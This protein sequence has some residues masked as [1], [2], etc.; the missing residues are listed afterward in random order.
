[1]SYNKKEIE[2][3][4]M[5]AT[6]F[7]KFL[8]TGKTA[9]IDYLFNPTRLNELIKLASQNKTPLE[10]KIESIVESLNS[11]DKKEVDISTQ[12]MV[13]MLKMMSTKLKTSF[14]LLNKFVV[15]ELGIGTAAYLVLKDDA[16]PEDLKDIGVWVTDNNLYDV[17]ILLDTD[18]SIND[19]L[20]DPKTLYRTIL[21][22]YGH[23]LTRD[24]LTKSDS[25][26]YHIK[27]NVL[28]IICKMLSIANILNGDKNQ[29]NASINKIYYELKPE[30]LANEAMSLDPNQ[31]VIDN[32]GVEPEDIPGLNV[33]KFVNLNIDKLKTLSEYSNIDIFNRDDIST[34]SSDTYK[35][36]LLDYADIITETFDDERIKEK[37]CNRLDRLYRFTDSIISEYTNDK[38]YDDDDFKE[39]LESLT[40]KDI[41]S[42]LSF[43]DENGNEVTIWEEVVKENPEL[44]IPLDNEYREYVTEDVKLIPIKE[45]ERHLILE[46]WVIPGFD[47]KL[48][49]LDWNPGKP[50]WITGTSQFKMSKLAN[51][52]ANSDDSTVINSKLLYYRLTLSPEE[53]NDLSHG[54]DVKAVQ[55]DDILN[56][57]DNPLLDYINDNPDLPY[58]LT[59][60]NEINNQMVLFYRWALKNLTQDI[61]YNK[62]L[63]I[64]EG[65]WISYMDPSVMS[66]QPIIV[67]GSNKLTEIIKKAK[68]DSE[69]DDIPFL[70]SVFNEIKNTISN[71]GRDVKSNFLNSLKGQGS[72][73]DWLYQAF[74]IIGQTPQSILNWMH[75]N[76]NV[77]TNLSRWTLQTPHDT[78]LHRAGA[79]HDQAF[80]L[81][82]LLGQLR[83]ECGM[84]VSALYNRNNI[85][86]DYS[87]SLTWA[88]GSKGYYWLENT[89]PNMNGMHGPY[90]KYSDIEKDLATYFNNLD[91]SKDYEGIVCAEYEYKNPSMNNMDAAQGGPFKCVGDNLTQ[92]INDWNLQKPVIFKRS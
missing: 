63:Y 31:L 87:H 6:N 32:Y 43:P 62:E 44:D 30:N 10:K 81:M 15:N 75:D 29:I 74:S 69:E 55:K 3:R 2:F 36:L 86:Y 19:F 57:M 67:V 56:L 68:T 54:R 89:L 83:I 51:K 50:L 80:F 4:N 59:E 22:E 17:I 33:N 60:E 49:Y 40:D 39:Y 71:Y 61:R 65:P 24:K 53:W 37:I 12:K 41:Y 77:N 92:Y 70:V 9:H 14:I 46:Q 38:E 85:N 21:H 52:L 58:N 42:T 72:K 20:K 5:I 7:T 45:Y 26:E 76:I 34:I 66:K 8:H 47:Y 11:D 79:S 28:F 90:N 18:R 27:S 64:I 88:K 48:N 23:Y 16:S 91:T 78:F 35:N 13:M 73:A 25:K 84:I 82:Y 1:M